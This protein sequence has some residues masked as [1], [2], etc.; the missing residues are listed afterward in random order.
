MKHIAIYVRVSTKEQTVINQTVKLVQF[1]KS[2]GYT[3][4]IYKKRNQHE[5]LVL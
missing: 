3:F 1:A 4:D 2:N 5:K